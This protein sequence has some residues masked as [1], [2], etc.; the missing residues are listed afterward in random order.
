M[1]CLEAGPSHCTCQ[2]SLF[3]QEDL[4]WKGFASF[5]C[6]L[7]PGL[8]CVSLTFKI[9]TPEISHGTKKMRFQRCFSCSN[10]WFSGEPAVNFQGCNSS[11][12]EPLFSGTGAMGCL[13]YD[14]FLSFR[15]IFHWT[16]NHDYGR[17]AASQSNN[18]NFRMQIWTPLPV[19]SG[20][21]NV[22]I[23]NPPTSR[24]K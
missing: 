11:S 8:V 23:Y 10:V 16:L 18:F 24:I 22:I 19:L 13:K 6:E 14:R 5:P 3:S 20:V 4:V 12:Q 9:Y 15:V 21:T 2:R 7:R 1:L 17:K